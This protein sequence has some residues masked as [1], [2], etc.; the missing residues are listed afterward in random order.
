MIHELR[1][2]R[3]EANL[4]DVT[5]ALRGKRILLVR[6]TRDELVAVYLA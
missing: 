6:Y 3:L 2:K 5:R 4:C 1:L